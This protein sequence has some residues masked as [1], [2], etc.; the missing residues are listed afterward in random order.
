MPSKSAPDEPPAGYGS[1]GASTWNRAWTLLHVPC[2][3]VPGT[4]GVNGFPMGVQVIAP[5][6]E[7]ALCL[8]A[9]R[10]L[11]QALAKPR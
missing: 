9:G 4:T 5:V 11:E 3:N 8:R 10:A 7:D 6:R 2:L 1:T